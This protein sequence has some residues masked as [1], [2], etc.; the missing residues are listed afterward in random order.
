MLSVLCSHSSGITLIGVI[1][2][3]KVMH[4]DKLRKIEFNNA[5]HFHSLELWMVTCHQHVKSHIEHWAHQMKFQF[6]A[7]RIVD[8]NHPFFFFLSI[9]VVSMQSG[10]REFSLQRSR[11]RPVS[12]SQAIL[13]SKLLRQIANAWNAEI[14]YR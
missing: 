13:V 8:Q 10:S 11:Y 14:G 2:Q 1:S 4:I 6:H 9:F 7:K 5:Q 12:H 3:S